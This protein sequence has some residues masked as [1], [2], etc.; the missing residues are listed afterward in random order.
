[1]NPTMKNLNGLPGPARRLRSD[2]LSANARP[3]PEDALENLKRRV[4]ARML[5]SVSEPNDNRLVRR[6]ANE[7]AALAWMLPYPLL[8]FPGLFEEKLQAARRQE[9]FQEMVRRRSV[10]FA[11]A[12]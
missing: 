10:E 8:V 6:A 3:T 5:E 2:E 1:M 9:A 12:E 11:F 4:L 7:A